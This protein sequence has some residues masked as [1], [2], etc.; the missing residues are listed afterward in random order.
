LQEKGED[1]LRICKVTSKS[2]VGDDAIR[3][4][5][6]EDKKENLLTKM[7]YIKTGF[8]KNIIEGE[9]LTLTIECGNKTYQSLVNGK[10]FE[11]MMINRLKEN[12]ATNHID[13]DIQSE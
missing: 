7:L 1:R 11:M 2:I 4:G 10:D 13:Y 6:G 5:I 3:K 12:G 8:K 9:H